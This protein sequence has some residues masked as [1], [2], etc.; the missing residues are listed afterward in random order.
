MSRFIVGAT[1]DDAPHLTKERKEAL[2]GSY[3]AFQRDAR[4][5]GIPQLGAGAVYQVSEA[6]LKVDPFTIPAHW[7]RAFGADTDQGAGNTAAVW[8]AI[9]PESGTVYLYD[10]Y[11][12][13]RQEIVVNAEAI[14]QRGAIPGVMDA[15]A[16]VVTPTD[17]MQLVLLYQAHGLDVVI[18]DKA[19]ETGIEQVWQMMTQGRLKVFSSLSPWFQEFRLY[20]RNERGVIVKVHDHLMDSTR[21]L[22]RSGLA[23]AAAIMGETTEDEDYGHGAAGDGWMR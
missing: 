22:V 23:R 2:Y 3:Q 17:A 6:E 10:C 7:K 19:V 14:K 1:W 4:T 16:L 9:D 18:P 5:R 21:Y 11:K 20:H 8:G 15:A 12:R 13:Q